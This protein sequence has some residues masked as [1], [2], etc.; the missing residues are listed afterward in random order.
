MRYFIVMAAIVLK[1]CSLT[2]M[3]LEKH[4]YDG[5]HNDAPDGESSRVIGI[6]V[7][8]DNVSIVAAAIDHADA[9]RKIST[10]NLNLPKIN[11]IFLLKQNTNRTELTHTQPK[12]KGG[13]NLTMM[14]HQLAD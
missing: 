7:H 4:K 9:L 6:V 2:S 1:Y 11:L 5:C 14:N 3:H 13:K 10:S 8:L 12:L